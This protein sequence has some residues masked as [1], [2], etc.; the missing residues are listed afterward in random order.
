MNRRREDTS[1]REV[2]QWVCAAESVK[3]AR[4]ETLTQG[5]GGKKARRECSRGKV[6]VALV[7]GTSSL[8]ICGSGPEGSVREAPPFLACFTLSSS[9]VRCSFSLDHRSF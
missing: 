8:K 7:D 2:T 9:M 3:V 6:Q 4:V 5:D 1:K